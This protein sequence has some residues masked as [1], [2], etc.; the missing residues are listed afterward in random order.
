MAVVN[1]AA[2]DLVKQAT[3]ITMG[4]VKRIIATHHEWRAKLERETFSDANIT[5]ALTKLRTLFPAT[6]A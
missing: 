5:H 2:L 4:N 1:F 6:Y 3:P